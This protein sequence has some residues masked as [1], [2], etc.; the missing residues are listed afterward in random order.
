MLVLSRKSGE[1]IVVGNNV[2]VRVLKVSGSHVR[3]GIVAPKAVTVHRQEIYRRIKEESE[4]TAY[5]DPLPDRTNTPSIPDID[6]EQRIRNVLISHGVRV[7]GQLKVEACSGA[8]T[9]SGYLPSVREKWLCV[10]C[11]R[12]VAGVRQIVDTLLAPGMSAQEN[13]E[14]Q[15]GKTD[16]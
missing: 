4:P 9:L 6:L 14:E 5:V 2:R 12:H 8:V 1:E 7:A 3:L 10:E 11:C 15:V 16:R 13:V